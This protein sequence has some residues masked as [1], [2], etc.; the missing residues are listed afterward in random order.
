MI[1]VKDE[2]SSLEKLL[3]EVNEGQSISV[4][5]NGCLP[6]IN[7]ATWCVIKKSENSLKILS[8]DLFNMGQ[9]KEILWK[10]ISLENFEKNV[11]EI[12]ISTNH[13][14]N[15]SGDANVAKVHHCCEDLGGA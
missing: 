4:L 15:P 14:I 2:I 6:E 11:V 3:L 5:M 8:R 9:E 12:L 1:V 7:N 13:Q 10:S